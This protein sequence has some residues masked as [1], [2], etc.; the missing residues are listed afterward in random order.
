[1]PWKDHYIT[2]VAM[3]PRSKAYRFCIH[4]WFQ[5]ISMTPL[6]ALSCS[7]KMDA[8]VTRVTT[9]CRWRFCT[10]KTST[11]A[12]GWCSEMRL[13]W[14]WCR[15]AKAARLLVVCQRIQ[16]VLCAI[17]NSKTY[18]CDFSVNSDGA[19]TITLL[20]ATVNTETTVTACT[21]VSPGKSSHEQMTVTLVF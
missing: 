5:S 21:V 11:S 18:L 9:I 3:H 8:S 14:M 4:V 17:W 19:E 13:C 6:W 12:S 16:T 7:G 2:L 20:N 1:M 15:Y 10:P